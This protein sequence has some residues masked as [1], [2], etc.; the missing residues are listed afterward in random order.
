M[1]ENIPGRDA[2]HTVRIG[3]LSVHL[4]EPVVHFRGTR[5]KTTPF[6]YEVL[7]Y[8]VLRSPTPVYAKKVIE[9]IT[10]PGEVPHLAP[11]LSLAVSRMRK[12]LGI[13]YLP[14]RGRGYVLRA[15]AVD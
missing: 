9:H 11:V 1:S 4:L 12:R 2:P 14:P 10:V 3:E 8:L 6:E 5:F 7:R 15:P 13:A